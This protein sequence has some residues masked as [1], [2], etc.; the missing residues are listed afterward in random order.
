MADRSRRDPGDPDAPDLDWLYG[1]KRTGGQDVGAPP[2][3]DDPTQVQRSRSR[4]GEPDDHAP[5]DPE[6]TRMLPTVERPGSDPSARTSTRRPYQAPPPTRP[7]EDGWAEPATGRPR[8]R[9]R[10]RLGWLKLVLL[11]WVVFLVAVPLIAWSKI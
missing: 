3:A 8:G 11:L 6:P 4:R 5:R 10:F 7:P 1:S 2:G 9:R